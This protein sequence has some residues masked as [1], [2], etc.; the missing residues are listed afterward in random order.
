MNVLD[1]QWMGVYLV[2]TCSCTHFSRFVAEVTAGTARL[3]CDPN[4]VADAVLR[5]NDNLPNGCLKRQHST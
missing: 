4:F 2:I 3:S 5:R 1:Y